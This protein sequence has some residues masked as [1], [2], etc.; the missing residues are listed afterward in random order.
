MC[1]K[2][3]H[4]YISQ[5]STFAENI[6]GNCYYRS[7][8]KCSSI[9][10]EARQHSSS[11]II[12][13]TWYLRLQI[14]GSALTKK[15]LMAHTNSSQSHTRIKSIGIFLSCLLLLLSSFSFLSFPFFFFVFCLFRF[16]LFFFLS[17]PFLHFFLLFVHFLQ[18]T[19]VCRAYA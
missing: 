11:S 19:C 12:L 5:S 13:G 1:Y 7:L 3:T 16:T 2:I 6:I 9:E 15:W 14:P 10:R 17:F 4:P 8:L 18:L